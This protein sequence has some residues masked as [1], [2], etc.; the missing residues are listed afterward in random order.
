VTGLKPMSTSQYA[1]Q[2]KPKSHIV[3][4]TIMLCVFLVAGFL[5]CGK[6]G[7]ALIGGL[8]GYGLALHRA[9]KSL[10]GMNGDVSGYALTLG[11]LAAVAV[12]ALL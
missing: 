5:L 6:Y 10:E 2:R 11:E 3:V 12:F 4:L 9:C 7:I 1:D 8:I